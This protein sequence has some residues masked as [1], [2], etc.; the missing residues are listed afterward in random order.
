[1]SLQTRPRAIYR[2]S[3]AA[4][5]VTMTFTIDALAL[6][7]AAADEAQPSTDDVQRLD[8]S[9]DAGFGYDSNAY[10]THFGSYTD[11][12]PTV[13]VPVTPKVQSGSFFP[14]DLKASYLS[15]TEPGM[16][17]E[18]SG[19]AS[20]RFYSASAL[21][22]ANEYDFGARLGLNTVFAR[23]R[24]RS[25]ELYAGVLA[26]HHQNI[27]VD[28]DNGDT[29]VTS[30][31]V[32][33][34]NRYVYSNF[35]A[36]V[37]FSR[38]IGAVQYGLNAVVEKRN[39]D[40]TVVVDQYDHT[41]AEF[42]GDINFRVARPSQ[43]KLSYAHTLRDFTE[44]SARDLNG[45][46]G[47]ANGLLKYTEDSIEVAS[48]NMLGPDWVGTVYYD[49]TRRTDNFLGYADYKAN[50]FGGRLI[51]AHGE[52][53]R[54]HLVV[55][56]QQRNYAHA[57]AYNQPT[58]PRL[59]LDR[60]KAALKTEYTGRRGESVWVALEYASWNTNDLRY[61]YDRGQLTVGAKWEY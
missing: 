43:L 33:I 42:G 61:D 9:I 60:N 2:A 7:T 44:R 19:Q 57:F 15:G 23:K 47:I 35:G 5:A 16:H 29:K 1:M 40:D 3:R 41:Y 25:N 30:A 13:A 50:E 22:N 18:A 46:Y 54:T 48:R 34:S 10:R 55:S 26:G 49:Y 36:E 38:E 59:A 39:Y 11:F 14:I 37:R 56:R 45:V 27:Y 24:A 6:R 32:D 21:R 4:I 12:A 58:Q 8:L 20:G 17:L 51:Y 28:R 53:A 52:H 31:Q